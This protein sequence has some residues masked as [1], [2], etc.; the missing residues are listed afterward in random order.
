MADS[1][2]RNRTLNLNLNLNL[3]LDLNLNLSLNL[4]LKLILNLILN[5]NLYHVLNRWPTLLLRLD[6]GF[7]LLVD[8]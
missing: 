5:L 1:L 3:N 2:C 7:V 4:I 8:E 6:A